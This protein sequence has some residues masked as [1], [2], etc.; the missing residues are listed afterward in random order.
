[1]VTPQIAEFDSIPVNARSYVRKHGERFAMIRNEVKNNVVISQENMQMR[2]HNL[3]QYQLVIMFI[4]Y[5]RQM[6]RHRNYKTN[7]KVYLS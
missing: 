7:T 4:F 1:M 3:Y 2:K 6:E 5:M